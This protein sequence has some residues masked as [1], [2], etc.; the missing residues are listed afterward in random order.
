MRARTL[1]AAALILRD[2]LNLPDEAVSLLE[3]CLDEAP[4]MTFAFEDLE[5]LL[6]AES[7]SKTW[8]TATGG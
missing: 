1:Y 2:E 7:D 6:K 3:R 4:D 8:P 5:A